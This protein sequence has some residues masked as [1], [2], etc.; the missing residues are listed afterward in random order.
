MSS[1]SSQVEPYVSPEKAAEF[2]GTTRRRIIDLARER[3]I[4][5]HP[6]RGGTKRNEWR[7]KLS[8]LDAHMRGTIPSNASRQ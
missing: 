1:Q 7:F 3:R 8:E 5:A 6:L 4:P 2:L